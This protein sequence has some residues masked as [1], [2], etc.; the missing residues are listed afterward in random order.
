MALSTEF[1]AIAFDLDGTLVDSAPGLAQA[2]D[3]ALNDLGYPAPG[4]ERVTTWIGN[5]ADIMIQRALTWA[6]QDNIDNA[7]QQQVRQNFDKHYQR[8]AALGSQLYP[9]VKVTLARLTEVGLPLAIVTNK[10]SVFV[11]PLLA[12][13]GIERYFNLVLGGD[14]VGA[15]K[16][17]PAPLFLVL[18]QLG[19][20]PQQLLFVGD[21]KNDI[22][23]AQAAKIPSA[24]LTY[25]Y[26]Y[27]EPISAS[28]PTYILTQFDQLLPLL[29]L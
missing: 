15:K 21:S 6:V 13:L 14:D 12:T 22:Q 7:L 25:G 16:P 10:P 28:Q 26:N 20:L 27:G 5:G 9:E 3:V 24:A 19:L 2:V 11:R 29:G 18:G 8:F 23:A 4:V 17:H 1:S